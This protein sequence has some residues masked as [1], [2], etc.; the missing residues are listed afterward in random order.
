MPAKPIPSKTFRPPDFTIDGGQANI[1]LSSILITIFVEEEHGRGLVQWSLAA[2]QYN[3]THAVGAPN[4]P[5]LYILLLDQAGGVIPN[6]AGRKITISP[7][8]IGCLNQGNLV[9]QGG[10]AGFPDDGD[11]LD[12]IAGV[13]LECERISYGTDVC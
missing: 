9:W 10:E 6:R 2:N 1:N 7:S 4:N 13:R 12:T 11:L 8:H 3:R 5:Y